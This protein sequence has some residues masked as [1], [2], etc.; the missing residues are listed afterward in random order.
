MPRIYKECVTCGQEFFISE[1]AQEF[2]ASQEG[3]QLPERCYECRQ[4]RRA[5]KAAAK[6]VVEVP[7]PPRPSSPSRY[8]RE[9]TA[10]FD[11]EPANTHQTD[12]RRSRKRLTRR[13]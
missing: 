7:R 11:D 10:N 2:F 6:A 9:A 1:K 4:R 13:D 5:E 8:V 12:R 3:F